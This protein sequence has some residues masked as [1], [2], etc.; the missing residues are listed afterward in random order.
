MQVGPGITRAEVMV[1]TNQIHPDPVV[2]TTP[3]PQALMHHLSFPSSMMKKI[4]QNNQALGSR[5]GK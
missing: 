5:R 4:T 1:T 3:L 2:H